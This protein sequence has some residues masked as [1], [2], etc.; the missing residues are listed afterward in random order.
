MGRGDGIGEVDAGELVGMALIRVFGDWV[1]TTAS[2][3]PLREG[4]AFWRPVADML[5]SK[6]SK[7]NR[8]QWY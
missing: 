6:A 5:V 3:K 4:R 7:S 1:L 8:G 2:S